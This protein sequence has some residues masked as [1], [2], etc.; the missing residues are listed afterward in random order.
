MSAERADAAAD[1]QVDHCEAN[2]GPGCKVEACNLARQWRNIRR[3]P[4]RNSV[5]EEVARMLQENGAGDGMV[6]LVRGMKVMA[7]QPAQ[8]PPPMPR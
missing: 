5:L 6:R 7:A 2:H 3:S 1:F 4:L 8:T